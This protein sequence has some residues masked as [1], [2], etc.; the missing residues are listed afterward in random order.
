MGE[1]VNGHLDQ[2]FSELLGEVQELAGAMNERLQSLEGRMDGLATKEQ[3]D[4][5][6]DNIAIIVQ[7]GFEE[8]FQRLDDQVKTKKMA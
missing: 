5:A 6:A 2:K 4:D 8:V 7:S 1:V 3:M